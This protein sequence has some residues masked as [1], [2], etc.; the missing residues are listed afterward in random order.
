MKPEL[1][2]NHYGFNHSYGY[3]GPWLDSYTHLT[4]DF[5]D[6]YDGI[7]QWHRNGELFDEEGHV[8]DLVTAEAVRFLTEIRNK[9]KPFLLYLP[10]SAP[11]TPCQEPAEWVAPYEGVIETASR[12]YFAAAITHMDDGIGKVREALAAEGVAENTIT[13]FFSDNGGSRGGDQTRWLVPPRQ[14]YMSYGSTE[15][16]GNNLPL[17]GWKGQLYEGGI[18]V[19]ALI[20][21][22]A[23]LDAGENPT[24]IQVCDVLPTLSVAA[25]IETPV[26]AS[27]EGVN[28]WG[29][30]TGETPPERT[31]YWAHRKDQAVR[32]GDWKL[33]KRDKTELFNLAEDPYETTD[34]SSSQPEVLERLTAELERNLA[35]DA[36]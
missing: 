11:H 36:Q 21:W 18:R 35:L 34:L 3:V 24:P 16:L 14:F 12:R 29:A 20:H 7:R 23:R 33:I 31:F 19:P 8:T 26:D 28:M 27:V 2:P 17:R 25:G 22:P 30:L 4:T 9:S 13:L 15:V 5:T 10:Y 32:Q 6:T 1:R